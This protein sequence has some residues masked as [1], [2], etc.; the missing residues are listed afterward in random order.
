MT[1]D[2]P[3]RYPLVPPQ[4]TSLQGKANSRLLAQEQLQQLTTTV[5]PDLALCN[6]F[7]F[8]QVKKKLHS[9]WFLSAEE[10]VKAYIKH[11]ESIPASE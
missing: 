11:A 9:I 7:I 2:S 10:A 5:Q 8:L 4:S 1:K 6:F 3:L